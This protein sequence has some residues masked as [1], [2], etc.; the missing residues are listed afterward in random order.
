MG[1]FSNLFGGGDEELI[2]YL[3]KGAVVLDVRTTGEYQGGHVKGSRNIPLQ[4]LESNLSTI[5]KW[6]KPVVT[7]CASGMRSGQAQRFLKSNGVDCINGGS[8]VKVNSLI[9]KNQ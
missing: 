7:C 6:D 8:W 3:K 4:S 9:V 5:K 1:I 2:S